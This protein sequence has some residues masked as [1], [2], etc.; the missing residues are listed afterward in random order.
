SDAVKV[1]VDGKEVTRDLF[2]AFERE[3]AV[4]PDKSTVEITAVDDH[5]NLR[6]LKR[7]VKIASPMSDASAK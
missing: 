5:N 6:K 4:D 3:I 7:S 2:G 1:T